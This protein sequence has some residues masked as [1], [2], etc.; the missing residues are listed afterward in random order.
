M[1]YKVIHK[2]DDFK[3]NYYKV[4]ID[5]LSVKPIN[6]VPGLTIKAGKVVL[7]DNDLRSEYIKQRI[8]RKID[9]IIKFMIRILNDED[10]TDSDTGMVLDEVNRLKGIVVNKYREYM[11]VSDY[12]SMLTKLILIEEE[13]KKSYNQKMYSNYLNSNYYEEDLRSNRGR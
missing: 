9:K 13:F 11:K 5:G 2:Q 12:K 7:I 8:N 1:K 3:L 10:T 4:A 6:K